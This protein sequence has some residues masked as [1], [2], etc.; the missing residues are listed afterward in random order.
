MRKLVCV[1]LA[2]SCLLAGCGKTS[3]EIATVPVGSEPWTTEFPKYSNEELKFGVAV[4]E[5]LDA[6][7][8]VVE[9]YEPASD[10]LEADNY[11]LLYVAKELTTITLMV[12]NQSDEDLGY[13]D[14]TV[15]GVYFSSD[16]SN[17]VTFCGVTLGDSTDDVESKFGSPGSVIDWK[18][19]DA[20][21]YYYGTDDD[22]RCIVFRF[23]DNELTYAFVMQGILD[24]Q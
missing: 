2:S 24:N 19:T 9:Q 20:V 22:S 7:W 15:T 5:Y 1:L 18:Q 3:D 16:M 17:N 12:T 21:R 23:N 4:N 11:I 14:C 6:G 13:I 8:H 10:I